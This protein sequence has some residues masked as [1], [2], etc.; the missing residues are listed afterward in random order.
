MCSTPRPRSSA[1]T[2]PDLAAGI[3]RAQQAI[4]SGDASRS[5]PTW[6]PSAAE[7]K[8]HDLRSLREARL[9]AIASAG[10]RVRARGAGARRAVR[11]ARVVRRAHGSFARAGRRA[12]VRRG[13]R[14]RRAGDAARRAGA[15]RGV[16]STGTA[17]AVA[18]YA[19]FLAPLRGARATRR[20]SSSR[21]PSC[22]CCSACPC[23]RTTTNGATRPALTAELFGVALTVFT[24][25]RSASG[26]QAARPADDGALRSPTRAAGASVFGRARA[27][28]RQVARR[29]SAARAP[30]AAVERQAPDAHDMMSGSFS[31]CTRARPTPTARPT[32]AWWWRRER[33]GPP[34]AHRRRP[35]PPRHGR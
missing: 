26:G 1:G 24:A 29:C 18:R 4:D 5:W 22:A 7:R 34:R 28:V 2:S 32:A 15:R 35:P 8:D 33:R 25:R 31:C 10:V 17:A 14:R 27:P 20:C 11:R 19:G 6:P 21:R 9:R 30:A 3:E 16:R 23:S 13:R 12:G